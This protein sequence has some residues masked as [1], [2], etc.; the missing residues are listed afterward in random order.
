MG[1]RDI[2]ATLP[3]GFRFYPSDEE[4]VCHYL[5][6]KVVANNQRLSKVFQK[7]KATGICDDSIVGAT[8]GASTSSPNTVNNVF[9]PAGYSPMSG[10]PAGNVGM[11]QSKR[12]EDDEYGFFYNV[13]CEEPNFEAAGGG[14]PL[15]IDEDFRFDNGGNGLLFI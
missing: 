9:L 3:P 2:E 1:L 5:Y 13:N 7:S 12:E 10:V 6:K 8:A 14:V 4:L 15:W 11:A